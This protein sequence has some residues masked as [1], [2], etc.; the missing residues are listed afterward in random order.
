MA[1]SII[2]GKGMEAIIE[3][4]LE[5]FLLLGVI[6]VNQY[7]LMILAGHIIFIVIIIIKHNCKI[8]IKYFITQYVFTI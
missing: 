6:I 8:K 3:I 2:V 7:L 4:M 5:I 1:K